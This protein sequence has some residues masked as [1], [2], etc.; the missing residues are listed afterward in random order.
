MRAASDIHGK[1]FSGPVLYR[2]PQQHYPLAVAAQGMTIT[3][4]DGREY[5]DLSGGAAVSV[6]GHSHPDVVAAITKQI[7][8]LAY[9]HT[10]FFTN[11]PQEQ[12]AQLLVERFE[13]PSARVYFAS[14]GSE[15][16]ETA[17]KLAWQYWAS[18]SHPDK[19]IIISREHSYHGNTFGVLSVS[20]NAGYPGRGAGRPRPHRQ[21]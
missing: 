13:D 11:E 9:A 18:A 10:A 20:G 21:D 14:G 19:K 6:L 1:K 3:D 7:Q 17:L 15:A 8:T 16:N 4:A 2:S 12:L 5:L